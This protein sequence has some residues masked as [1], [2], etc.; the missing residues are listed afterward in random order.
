M[1]TLLCFVI[2]FTDDERCNELTVSIQS[3][4]GCFLG[5]SL[6]EVMLAFDI[7]DV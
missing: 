1:L 7:G 2:S 3:P 6:R 5:F 4:F